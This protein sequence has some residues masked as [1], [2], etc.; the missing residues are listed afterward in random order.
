[1][2]CLS[3]HTTWESSPETVFLLLPDFSPLGL[4]LLTI[5]CGTI[6]ARLCAFHVCGFMYVISLNSHSEFWS[7]SIVTIFILYV[8]KLDTQRSNDF[9]NGIWLIA[10]ES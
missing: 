1:M 6:E 4:I 10:S 7:L 8:K 9:T 3:N 2:T 5:F